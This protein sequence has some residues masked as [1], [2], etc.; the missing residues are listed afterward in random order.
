MCLLFYRHLFQNLK[1]EPLPQ[2]DWPS[3][4][5]WK[6]ELPDISPDSSSESEDDQ[7]QVGHRRKVNRKKVLPHSFLY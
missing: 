1:G 6:D 5:Y 2:D 7:E 4:E 3:H